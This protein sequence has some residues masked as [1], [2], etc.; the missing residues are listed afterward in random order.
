M[1]TTLSEIAMFLSKGEG[2]WFI[3]H[4]QLESLYFDM[5]GENVGN[6]EKNIFILNRIYL[7]DIA[8]ILLNLTFE[9][10]L[11]QGLRSKTGQKVCF[12]SGFLWRGP[13]V[14][15]SLWREGLG[16]TPAVKSFWRP[17]AVCYMLHCSGVLIIVKIMTRNSWLQCPE[18]HLLTL[19][20]WCVFREDDGC[21]RRH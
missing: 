11:D 21:M 15:F 6:K 13:L 7:A 3:I 10:M 1:F 18:G 16:R 2:R 20:L 14:F 8:S 19:L 5:I 4:W 12:F 9:Q 17:L